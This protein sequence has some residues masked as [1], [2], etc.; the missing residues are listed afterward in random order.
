MNSS[1]QLGAAAP[2][3][4]AVGK[5]TQIPS[6]PGSG[7]STG[8]RELLIHSLFRSFPRSRAPVSPPEPLPAQIPTTE[9][10]SPK[11]LRVLLHQGWA[12]SKESFP[13]NSEDFP[14][15]PG[16]FFPVEEVFRDKPMGK[17]PIPRFPPKIL[18]R[19]PKKALMGFSQ[20]ENAFGISWICW[21]PRLG[22]CSRFP[23]KTATGIH[24]KIPIPTQSMKEWLG[25]QGSSQ[26][27][28]CLWK[29]S[30][31][32]M[33][34][35]FFIHGIFKVGKILRDESAHPSSQTIRPK[36]LRKIPMKLHGAKGKSSW[37]SHSGGKSGKKAGITCA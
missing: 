5:P 32:L 23:G 27:S 36:F 3:S 37:K 31:S 16:S 10:S 4:A 8:I 2:G 7:G 34:F 29:R 13:K 1:F 26:H 9:S 30:L 28:C 14:L 18:P 20:Q 21:E 17:G 24:G 25:I 12:F 11:S 35:P 15:V 33:F 22:S 19:A 6:A